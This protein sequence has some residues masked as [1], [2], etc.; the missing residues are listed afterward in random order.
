M[1]RVLRTLDFEVRRWR[2]RAERVLTQTLREDEAG[3]RHAYGICQAESLVRLKSAFEFLWLRSQPAR[4]KGH[5][6]M[7]EAALEATTAL[8]KEDLSLAAVI[9]EELV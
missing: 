4:G 9:S 8:L 1:R 5:G 7:D 6:V 3:G 2:Q